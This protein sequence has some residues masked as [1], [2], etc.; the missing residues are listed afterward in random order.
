MKFQRF[1]FEDLVNR[2]PWLSVS[3]VCLLALVTLLALL[4]QIDQPAV[5]YEEF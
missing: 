3:L 1:R 2:K 4:Y 5:I